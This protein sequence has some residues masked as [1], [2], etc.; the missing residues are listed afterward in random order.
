[1]YILVNGGST[2][3]GVPVAPTQAFGG[4]GGTIVGAIN[5]VNTVYTLPTSPSSYAEVFVD[6]LYVRPTN[7]TLV[8]GTLTF[9]T[10][11]LPGQSLDVVYV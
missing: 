4:P 8:G 9:A 2:G 7:Y 1:M 11:L 3:G 10:A 6:D 5:G